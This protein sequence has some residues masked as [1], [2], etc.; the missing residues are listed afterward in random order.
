M[1]RTRTIWTLAGLAWGLVVG[2]VT[3]LQT[4]AF[5]LGVG[6][7]FIFG[8]DRWPDAANWVFLGLVVVAGLVP[9]VLLAWIG[10]RLGVAFESET[11]QRLRARRRGWYVLMLA[12]SAM[13]LGAAMAW[14]GSLTDRARRADRVAAEEQFDQLSAI[15]HRIDDA[16][17]ARPGEADSSAARAGAEAAGPAAV[18]VLVEMD[19]ARAGEYL[20]G[21]TL[22]E[23]TYDSTLAAGARTLT[24]PAGPA[25]EGITVDTADIREGYRNSVLGGRGGVLVDEDW[26]LRATLRP[27]LTPAENT[28]LPREEVQ[29]LGLG[30][31]GL[32]S[33]GSMPLPVR[34][35]VP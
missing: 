25:V 26:T 1:L 19:G 11:R 6:W 17:V 14:A 23:P 24:L 33:E 32:I 13:T 27:V 5:L 28:R 16:R 12:L 20:L 30:D 9:T 4:A 31:S 3:A 29:N 22:R 34:F 10:Q 7:L 35:Q 2:L 8:D 18:T 21:W 15:V